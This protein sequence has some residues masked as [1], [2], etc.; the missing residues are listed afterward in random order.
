MLRKDLEKLIKNYSLY[1]IAYTRS[2]VDIRLVLL[3]KYLKLNKSVF[4]HY[5]DF[6]KFLNKKDQALF[7][8]D[9]LDSKT[10]IANVFKTFRA[11]SPY[12]LQLYPQA[13]RTQKIAL[14]LDDKTF[15]NLF[16]SCK[17]FNNEKDKS[18]VWK[19][20]RA[21]YKARYTAKL[22]DFNCKQEIVEKVIN[23]DVIN[24]YTNLKTTLNCLTGEGALI[25]E[26]WELY[27]LSGERKAIEHAIKEAKLTKKTFNKR[28][29]TVL[30]MAIMSGQVSA[31]KQV[32]VALKITPLEMLK[33]KSHLLQMAGFRNDEESYQY[34]NSFN[35][36]NIRCLNLS[37]EVNHSQFEI[38]EE[39]R[40]LPSVYKYLQ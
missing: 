25:Q 36:G 40:E 38:D 30:D 4:I 28:G 26:P 21:S 18:R 29:F 39:K 12:R 37:P 1:R 13:I 22:L 31:I 34:L 6:L 3:Q 27:L 8:K 14:F 32:E 9:F 24:N 7:T 33:N 23:A 5:K 16:S 11:K 10:P 35:I 2:K 19:E 20:K 15:M 17:L